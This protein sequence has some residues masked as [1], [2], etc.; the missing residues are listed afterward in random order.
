V[1]DDFDARLNASGP[2][3]SVP[4]AE[5][6]CLTGAEAAGVSGEFS[7]ALAAYVAPGSC[8]WWSEGSDAVPASLR[9]GACLH[10]A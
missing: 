6:W 7:D 3:G 4:G 10:D 5:S 9:S 2:V 8:A 1:L